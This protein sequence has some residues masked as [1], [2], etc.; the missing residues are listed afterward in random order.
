M[1]IGKC[2]LEY[3]C[4]VFGHWVPMLMMYLFWTSLILKTWHKIKKFCYLS[5]PAQRSKK[6]EFLIKLMKKGYT[7]LNLSIFPFTQIYTQKVQKVYYKENWLFKSKKTK[8]VIFCQ[9]PH[10]SCCEF[11]QNN[12]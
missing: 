2:W 12:A 1:K 9:T 3:S 11:H 10:K 8:K 7:Q 5:V 4:K 6:L